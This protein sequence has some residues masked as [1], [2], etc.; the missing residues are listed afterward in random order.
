MKKKSNIFVVIGGSVSVIIIFGIIA[1][2]FLSSNSTGGGG[3]TGGNGSGGGGSGGGGG[4][5]GT[6]F[7]QGVQ[8]DALGFSTQIES[9]IVGSIVKDTNVAN[10][11][12]INLQ[13][14]P[15][16][17]WHTAYTNFMMKGMKNK[18]ITFN[19]VNVNGVGEFEK[20]GKQ[21]VYTCD[22]KNWNLMA[23]GTMDTAKNGGTYTAKH[24]FECDLAEIATYYPYKYSDIQNY[25][26]TIK[27]KPN[28][29]VSVIGKS[30]EG[31]DIHL[32]EITDAGVSELQK[33]HVIIQT[34]Q[35]PGETAGSF[36]LQGMI[37]D[38]LAN[39]GDTTKKFHFYIVPDTNPDGI[40][41]GFTRHNAVAGCTSS[42]LLCDMNRQWGGTNNPDVNVMRN[43]YLQIESQYGIDVFIDI[44]GLAGGEER[45]GILGNGPLMQKFT[46]LMRRKSNWGLTIG[47]YQDVN[48]ATTCAISSA[49]A[50]GFGCVNGADFSLTFEPT[51]RYTYWNQNGMITEGKHLWKSI[52]ET[53]YG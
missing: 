10:T 2:L 45:T 25:I 14:S 24:T 46:D 34:R 33:K 9:G 6:V 29:I 28:V 15:L 18:Q 23:V 4:T 53:Y 21:M 13:P 42:N 17:K 49:T 39:G 30:I 36:V 47:A 38:L 5:G 16:G 19:V 40:Y 1:F 52:Y 26:N 48:T 11:Y 7:G 41:H 22:G 20:P 27:T 32:I 37:D 8:F 31:R 3:G 50:R 35:H 51:M 44:H 43:K 12:T